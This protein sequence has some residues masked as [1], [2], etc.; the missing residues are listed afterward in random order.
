MADV[1]IAT[2]VPRKGV[3]PEVV[4]IKRIR[5]EFSDDA[6]FL[7][8]FLD[9]ARITRYLDHP[10]IARII[11]VGGEA[12]STYLVM[13]HVPGLNLKTVLEAGP[14][15]PHLA[16][17]IGANVAAA[18]HYAHERKDEVGQ[19]LNIV[20]RD[21]T[22][23]NVMITFDGQVKLLDFGI[24]VARGRAEK[25]RA[26]IVKGKW[27][28]LSPEQVVGDSVDRRADVFTLGSL[29]YEMITAK[30]AFT[31]DSPVMV[32]RGVATEDPVSP[33]TLNPGVPMELVEIILRCLKK[34]RAERFQTALDVVHELEAISG[35]WALLSGSSEQESLADYTRRRFAER[36]RA[37]TVMI[38]RC[39]SEA[40]IVQDD[41]PEVYATPIPAPFEEQAGDL[42]SASPGRSREPER[43]TPSPAPAPSPAR[44]PA[45]EPEPDEGER[46]HGW[47]IALAVLLGVALGGGLAAAV[48]FLVV[49]G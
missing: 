34:R 25:T 47:L 20:H 23:M 44:E 35:M 33:T 19:P 2:H 18:L 48:W 42:S 43:A 12:Q 26:G 41:G 37:M 49:N 16:A 46:G 40:K 38:E 15:P 5:K 13:E 28:Y 14:L 7:R 22:P 31:G 9:E 1:F 36:H 10:N 6:T 8:M 17:E 11:D 4:A 24:A 45:P 27:S 29:L 30:R 3:R 39:L 21:V 32:L